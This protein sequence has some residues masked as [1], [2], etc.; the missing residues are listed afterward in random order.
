M[1]VEN[2]TTKKPIHNKQDD[3]KIEKDIKILFID[4]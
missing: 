1:K 3:K 2:K 4:V